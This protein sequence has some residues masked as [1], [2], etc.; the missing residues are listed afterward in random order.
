MLTLLPFLMMMLLPNATSWTQ[1]FNSQRLLNIVM[2]LGRQGAVYDLANDIE[3]YLSQVG[4]Y[5][6]SLA[7]LA[8]T[9]GFEHTKGLISTPG[10]GYATTTVSD[11]IWTFNRALLAG[12]DPKITF[13]SYLA[14]N[15]CGAGD[16]SVAS[17][18]CGSAQFG[19]WFKTED[20]AVFMKETTEAK[21]RL[22]QTL[23]KFV[24]EW[25]VTGSFPAGT[26]SAGGST[27][28]ASLV[29]TG[30]T[31]SNCTGLFTF[32]GIPLECGDLFSYWGGQVTYNYIGP[33]RI[34]LV[35]S[36][37]FTYATGGRQYIA[38]EMHY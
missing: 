2:A 30:V 27:T 10:I 5:P 22:N 34:A 31:A 17:D 1:I 26:L 23:M 29:G 4:Q 36:T 19:D 15:T 14:S 8:A 35:A 33:S 21:E 37:P 6:V 18:W 11:A 7:T 38:A 24:A 16:F 9:P 20:R 25:N 12:I 13:T 3:R 28:L 32:A